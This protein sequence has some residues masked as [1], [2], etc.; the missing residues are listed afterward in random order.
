MEEAL[1][2]LSQEGII[3]AG[4][5]TA[6]EVLYVGA[7]ASVFE[8]VFSGSL[9]FGVRRPMIVKSR[10]TM[11]S[12]VCCMQMLKDCKQGVGTMNEVL[13]LPKPGGA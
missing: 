12:Y 3:Q 9:I 13:R 4:A 6:W 10:G 1:T 11:Q 5:E 8:E 2:T 7:G